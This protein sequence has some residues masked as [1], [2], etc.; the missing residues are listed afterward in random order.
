MTGV[1]VTDVARMCGFREPLYFS[2]MFKK[3]YGVAPSFY[4]QSRQGTDNAPILNSDLMKVLPEE[5]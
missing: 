3:K 1:S 2:R 4:V 5:K